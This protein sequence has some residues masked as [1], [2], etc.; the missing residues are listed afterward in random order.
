MFL[1]HDKNYLIT[2]SNFWEVGYLEDT[3]TKTVIRKLKIQF[4]RYGISDTCTSDNGP[5][6]ASDEL[7]QFNK[8]WNFEHV[9]SSPKFPQTIGKIK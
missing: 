4:A 8:D 6:F 1:C 9:T 7:K 3:K 2:F 5:Q